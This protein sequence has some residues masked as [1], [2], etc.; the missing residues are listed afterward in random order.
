M[1][2]SIESPSATNIRIHLDAEHLSCDIKIELTEHKGVLKCCREFSL[3]D[4]Y[5]NI[6][7]SM[8]LFGEAAL[9]LTVFS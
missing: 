9:F 7:T 1:W 3:F 5:T 2:I 8:F 4:A 6:I